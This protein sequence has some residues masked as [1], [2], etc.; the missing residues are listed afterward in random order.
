MGVTPL[1]AAAA[2]YVRDSY[3]GS[4]RSPTFDSDPLIE[5][6]II[7]S[8]EILLA[9]GADINAKVTDGHSRT[10]RIARRAVI[11]DQEGQTAL[12][13][14]A[15]HGWAKV[16]QFMV[17]H[18]AAVDVVDAAGKT[19][20]DAALATFNGEATPGSEAVAAILRAALGNRTAAAR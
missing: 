20:L 12:Y 10:A 18:G 17:E 9:A 19:P 2:V 3:F 6:K 14:A 8:F 13:S 4:N 11:A 1:M 7:E 15:G 5:D 16:V